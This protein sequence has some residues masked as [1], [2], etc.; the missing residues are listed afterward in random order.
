M[1][2]SDLLKACAYKLL[3]YVVCIF[4]G[5]IIG[6]FIV[7]DHMVP[8][9]NEA[10]AQLTAINNKYNEVF[11]EKELAKVQLALEKQKEPEKLYVKGED[12][13]EYVYIEKEKASDPDV[14]ITS[15]PQEIKVSYNGE[16][17]NLP[18]QKTS[19]SSVVGGTLKMTQSSSATLDVTD[20]V[21]REIANTILQKDA[22]IAKLEH[23]KKVTK[24]Q[25]RQNT[26]WATTI[27]ATAGYLIA[28]NK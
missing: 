25:G 16:I 23:E 4:V 22:Q 7:Y 19:E 28:K 24:R 5:L 17:Y 13:T 8:K 26:F 27:G 9:I 15:T 11:K 20:I 3:P 10:N 14:D 18:M 21:N 12:K 2:F 6:G 1:N